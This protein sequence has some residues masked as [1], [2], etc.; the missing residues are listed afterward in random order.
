MGSGPACNFATNPHIPVHVGRLQRG[1]FRQQTCTLGDHTRSRQRDSLTHCER[2]DALN[3]PP[4]PAVAPDDGF[5]TQSGDGEYLDQAPSKTHSSIAKYAG[6]TS[7]APTTMHWATRNAGRAEGSSFCATTISRIG[8]SHATMATRMSAGSLSS[9]SYT[10][11]KTPTTTANP[12]TTAST[13]LAT[14]RRR[15]IHIGAI[16]RATSPLLPP[17]PCPYSD[18]PTAQLAG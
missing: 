12:P 10:A 7:S 17:R 16:G 11:K 1:P 14:M 5:L 4:A 6:K 2:Q 9:V 15:P 13:P 8:L 18:R 3:L